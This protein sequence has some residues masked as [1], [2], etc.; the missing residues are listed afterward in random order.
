M[1]KLIVLSIIAL[2][3]SVSLQPIIA[4]KIVSVEKESDYNN[5]DFEEVKEYLFQ[6]IIDIANNP[7]VKNLFEQLKYNQKIFTSDYDYKSLFYQLFLKKP[8]LLLSILFTKPSITYEYL[9]KSYNRDIK[10][11]NILGEKEA[12]E[13]TYSVKISN[14][15]LMDELNNIIKND[16]ELSNRILTLEIMNKDLKLEPPFMTHPIICAFMILMCIPIFIL[17]LFF[18]I[19][20]KIIMD[21]IDFIKKH[22]VLAVLCS[23]I[24]EGFFITLLFMAVFFS[25]AMV[26]CLY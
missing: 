2:F 16:K 6:T 9:D 24:A 18:S 21:N 8:R 17:L 5:V 26:S 22:P 15:D 4:E 1:K 25:G 10:C 14:P 19:P 11:V 20:M 23:F 12:L 13:M 7:D 3:V